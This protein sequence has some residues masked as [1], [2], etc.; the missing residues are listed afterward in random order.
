MSSFS[1]FDHLNQ[2][3]KRKSETESIAIIFFLSCLL[4][5][6]WKNNN[7]INI[8]KQGIAV[9]LWLRGICLVSHRLLMLTRKTNH[10]DI[11][12]FLKVLG[13]SISL[14]VY[15]FVSVSCYSRKERVPWI[16]LWITVWLNDTIW[17]KAKTLS[18]DSQ[19]CNVIKISTLFSVFLVMINLTF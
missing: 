11:G 15:L 19:L 5:C 13:I 4:F 18:S 1:E 6:L 17:Q 7:S 14:D 3:T 10:L 8:F 9:K 12:R 2:S 16:K